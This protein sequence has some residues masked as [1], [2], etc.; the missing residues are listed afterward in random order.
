VR[1]PVWYRIL[2]ALAQLPLQETKSACQGHH[3]A[4]DNTYQSAARKPTVHHRLMA[5]SAQ[6]VLIPTLS[7]TLRVLAQPLPLLPNLLH[8]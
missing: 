3:Y 7:R 2:R 1:I 4:Q 6:L 5:T 8:R